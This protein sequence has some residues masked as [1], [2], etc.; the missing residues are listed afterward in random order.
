MRF[1]PVTI[2]DKLGRE[3]ILRSAE[4]SDGTDLVQYLKVTASETPFL[5]REPEEVTITV[6]QETA[7]L[8]NKINDE[9]ELM[10]IAT[11]DGKHIGNCS[12]MSL[13]S[14]K[15]YSHRCD[16]AIALYK[17]YWGV[18]IGKAM[19]ETALDIAKNIGYEQAELEVIADNK[20]AISLYEKLGFVKYGE[21]PNNMKYSDG[22]Y[23]NAYWM[24]KKL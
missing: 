11:L 20:S 5:I 8:E 21:F 23:A 17:E 12:V 14:Y 15:R 2:K 22:S 10:L 24:M 1:G 16:I 19:L 9:R 3:I 18:G 13:G 4:V 7:F 6:Q